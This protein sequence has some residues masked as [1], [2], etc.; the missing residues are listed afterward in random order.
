MK[1]IIVQNF[2]VKKKS[3]KMWKKK[4]FSVHVFISFLLF[5][6]FFQSP[7]NQYYCEEY[8]MMQPCNE[9]FYVSHLIII[10]ISKL[11]FELNTIA[12]LVQ[13]SLFTN[14][15]KYY[16]NVIV[17]NASW[18]NQVINFNSFSNGISLHLIFINCNSIITRAPGLAQY[19]FCQ[20]SSIFH[21]DCNYD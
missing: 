6:W 2:K 3:I 11:L 14:N 9:Y 19:L 12:I 15:C 16:N 18:C 20:F 8:I 10:L 21:H 17:E 7:L 13:F 5:N 1:L 4:G